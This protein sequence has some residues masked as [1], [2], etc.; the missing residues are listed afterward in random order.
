MRQNEWGNTILDQKTQGNLRH[1]YLILKNSE[2]ERPTMER[3]TEPCGSKSAIKTRNGSRTGEIVKP[4]RNR[5]AKT[6]GH[7]QS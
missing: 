4:S 3:K 2:A 6:V 1:D 5:D 7:I